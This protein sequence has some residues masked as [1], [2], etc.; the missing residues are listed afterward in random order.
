MSHSP[1]ASATETRRICATAS[2]I[3]VEGRWKLRDPN[4]ALIDHT[5]DHADRHCYRV[6]RV[7]DLPVTRFEIAIPRSFTLV[8]E[9]KYTLEIFDD[10]PQYEAFSVHLKGSP[11]IY[12]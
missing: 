2:S 1:D 10:S 4:G 3:F 5:L 11:S 7:L 9:P 12:V 8:F 6:H